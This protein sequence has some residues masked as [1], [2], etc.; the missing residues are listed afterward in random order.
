MEKDKYVSQERI[1]QLV[2]VI[3]QGNQ[4]QAA[5]HFSM[6]EP[7]LARIMSGETANPRANQLVKIAVALGITVDS[8]L[9][10]SNN[11]G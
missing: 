6:A 7:T 10:R 1:R 4:R 2:D 11:V 8:L 9:V 3:Y 5:R